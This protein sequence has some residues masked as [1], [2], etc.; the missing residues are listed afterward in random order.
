MR[1]LLTN[2][3]GIKAPGIEALIRALHKD[4]EIIVAAP[5]VQQSGMSNALTIGPA[6]EVARD[7]ALEKRYGIEA[8]AIG[9]TPADSAKLY[10]EALAETAPDLVVSGI[11]HGANLA[12]DVIYSGTVGAAMEGYFHDIPS[13][14]LSLDVHSE[15]N[16]DDAAA[17]FA[18]DFGMMM[19]GTGKAFLYNV[20][21][22][23]FLKDGRAQYVFGRQ[24]KRDYINAFTHEERDG[25]LF[26]TMAGEVYDS[27]KGSATDIYATEQG[28]ISVTPLVTDMTDYMELDRRL[29][30]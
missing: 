25:R 30:K 16:Y 5:M 18:R 10:I 20:N 15:L 2:D 8:W 21:Y 13:F 23:V 17:I 1:I 12:T 24:G 3:D 11:N 19:P 9:G 7:E 4:H 29:E 28:Y 14:A 26:Y 27:D 6:I 22:P